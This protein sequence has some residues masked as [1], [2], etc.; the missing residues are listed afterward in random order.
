M[1]IHSNILTKW[2]DKEMKTL[3]ACPAVSSMTPQ[4]IF[5]EDSIL[6]AGKALNLDPCP[7]ITG[8]LQL[9][10]V[11]NANSSCGEPKGTTASPRVYIVSFTFP[12]LGHQEWC[13]VI[14]CSLLRTEY[15]DD[16]E[17]MIKLQGKKKQQSHL[18]R[19]GLTLFGLQSQPAKHR[20]SD[21]DG[22]LNTV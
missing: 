3:D 2:V 10:S 13:D 15:F 6:S 1:Q 11:F 12:F 20:K 7:L 16:K 4:Q 22:F 18:H 9:S 8:N 5:W 21:K 14:I 17:K 19:A